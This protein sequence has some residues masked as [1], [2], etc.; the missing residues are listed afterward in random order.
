MPAAAGLA[1]LVPL[2]LK[3]GSVPVLIEPGSSADSFVR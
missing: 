1:M 3:Y 2:R